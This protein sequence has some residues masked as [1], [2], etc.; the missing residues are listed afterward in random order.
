MKME[1]GNTEDKAN[2]DQQLL[3]QHIV[4]IKSNIVNLSQQASYNL[5]QLQIGWSSFKQTHELP[6]P[7]TH[8]QTHF[9]YTPKKNISDKNLSY[10]LQQQV[11]IEVEAP[12]HNQ[13]GIKGGSRWKWI[14]TVLWLVAATGAAVS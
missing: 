14:L 10:L 8:T 4:V 1:V 2:I 9:T 12:G 3:P 11:G 5:L 7:N 13:K 6:T